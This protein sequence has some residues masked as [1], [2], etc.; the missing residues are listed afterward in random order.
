MLH[1]FII[2]GAARHMVGYMEA[3]STARNVDRA[4]L[5]VTHVL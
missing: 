3:S 5:D 2:R 4:Q 1:F